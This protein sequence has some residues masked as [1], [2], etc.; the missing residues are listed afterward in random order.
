MERIVAELAVLAAWIA[1]EADLHERS[2]ALMKFLAKVAT[3]LHVADHVYIVGGAVRDFYID[4][5]I[6]DLDVVIDAVALGGKKDSEWFAKQLQRAIPAKTNLTTNQYGVAILSVGG[7]WNLD[8]LDLDGEQIEIANARK[9]SYGGEEGKGYKPH[10]VEPATIEED[11]CRREFTYNCLLWRLADVAN[12]PDKAA[13]LDLTGLGISDLE[14]GLLRTPVDPNKTFRD[15]PT[16]MLRAIKFIVRYGHDLTPDV[17]KAIKKNAAK[18]KAVPS[19]AVATLL[20]DTLLNSEK[21]KVAIKLMEDLG[22]LDVVAE[23]IEDDPVLNSTMQNWASDKEVQLMFDVMDM[24]LVTPTQISFLDRNQQDQLREMLPELG[25]T[26]SSD[27]LKALKQPGRAVD[28]KSL[29]KEF[30]L[31]G[32]EIQQITN[33]ARVVLLADPSL[34]KSKRKLTDAVRDELV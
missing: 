6:K 11:V 23:M 4:R 14:K 26:G 28:M 17:K 25:A 27:L 32:S 3:R 15:D 24:G 2:T 19:N 7:S 22:L 30:G 5:P 10:M 21:Y 12:G 9:E 16:R 1:V 31:K 13:I 8:G 18:L 20:I 34:L 29:I 33:A